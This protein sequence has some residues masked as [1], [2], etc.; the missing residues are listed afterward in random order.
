MRKSDDFT[1]L[2]ARREWLSS[3]PVKHV[4]VLA[5]PTLERLSRTDRS[6]AAALVRYREIMSEK[7][8][9]AANDNHS[10]NVDA[11][12]EI[13]PSVDELL[14]GAGGE[15]VIKFASREEVAGGW[16]IRWRDGALHAW[17]GGQLHCGALVFR[18]GQLASWG[19]TKRGKSLS[20]VD[21]Q[22]QL[23]GTHSVGRTEEAVRFLLP[24]NDNAPIAKGAMFLGGI[25]GKK[26]N[27]TVPDL[28]ELDAADKLHADRRREA[29]RVSLGLHAAVLDAAISD[30]T[31]KEIGEAF[32]YTGKTAERRGIAAI[33]IA[34]AEFQK[35]AA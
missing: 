31:A 29:V 3:L 28:G 12:R 27:T 10:S 35:I 26:G 9:V 30:S 8:P 33:R 24:A 18:K 7:R 4:S 19:V 22:R 11:R 5:S 32:G 14:V 16:W 21:R 20:P 25:K 1:N 6:A 15:L 13:R 23:R 34:L 2:A 17:C